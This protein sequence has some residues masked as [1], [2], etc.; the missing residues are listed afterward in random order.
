MKFMTIVSV[1]ALVAA[2]NMKAASAQDD[3]AFDDSSMP[4]AEEPMNDDLSGLHSDDGEEV[5]P[6]KAEPVV[7]KKVAQKEKRHAAKKAK[8][9]KKREEKKQTISDLPRFNFS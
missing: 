4:A 3:E 1:L 5:A 8:K 9:E 7:P 2:I 6:V